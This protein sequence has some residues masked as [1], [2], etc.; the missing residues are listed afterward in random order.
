M[1]TFG[2]IR[3]D[4]VAVANEDLAA[5]NAHSCG[6]AGLAG[7][8]PG[9]ATV[10]NRIEDGDVGLNGTV[11]PPFRTNGKKTLLGGSFSCTVTG[12]NCL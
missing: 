11:L 1:A 8:R 2:Q 5:I 10:Y 9:W 4:P 12:T 6:R 3:K 7:D